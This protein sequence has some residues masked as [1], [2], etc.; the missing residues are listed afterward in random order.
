MKRLGWVVS[1][2][3]CWGLWSCSGYAQP[4]EVELVGPEPVVND[5]SG[6]YDTV[7]RVVSVLSPQVEELFD[8]R[9]GEWRHGFS[10]ALW[11]FTSNE[12]G[13]GSL[14][15]GYAFGDTDEDEHNTVYGGL[16][17]DL[18]GLATRYL[19]ETLKS[20]FSTGLL[21]TASSL[22]GKYGAVG[23]FFGRD[24]SQEEN[25]VGVTLGGAIQF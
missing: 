11:T 1:L 7:K 4:V 5:P 19:P 3:V 25:V 15:A 9:D 23:F 10:A 16:K 22:L 8:F 17:L 13:L 12:I 24:F 20:P 6:A 2:V 14:R 18:P 21:H